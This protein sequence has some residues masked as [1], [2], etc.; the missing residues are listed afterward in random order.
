[1]FMYMLNEQQQRSLFALAARI[2]AADRVV[3]EAEVDYLNTL[4]LESGLL[5]KEPMRD[6]DKPVD[7]DIFD[8]RRAQFAVA[9]ELLILA[10]TDRYYD[11]S[12]LILWDDV[13]ARFEFSQAEKEHLRGN[14]EIIALLMQNFEELIDGMDTPPPVGEDR[15]HRTDRRSGDRR[16][17]SR[18]DMD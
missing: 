17:R 4:I 18:R 3:L 14:A 1:M 7:L 16:A 9:L 12:E 11:P 5:D 10:N 15:R 6:K 8:T 13:M 2:I